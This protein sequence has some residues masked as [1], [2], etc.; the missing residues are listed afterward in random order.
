METAIIESQ[1]AGPSEAQCERFLKLASAIIFL[2]FFQTYTIAP[3]IPW[4]AKAFSVSEQ[5]VGLLVPAYTLPYAVAGLVCGALADRLGRRGLLFAS[6]AGIPLFSF[7]FAFAPN[8]QS[9][10]AV[11]AV[12]GVCNS[13]LVVMSLTLVGDVFP[14]K[15]RG[16]AT[17]WI[18][19]AI[20][21]G[22]A[23]GSTVAG[24][25][26]PI[27]GWRGLFVLTGGAATLL[28]LP[29]IN[30]WPTLYVPQKPWTSL[31]HLFA[32]Y[33]SILQTGRALRTYAFIFLN[34]MFHSGAF[35]WLGVH[36]HNRYGLGELGIG[37]ALL[38][39]GVPGFLLGPAIGRIV[40]RHGRRI[41]L[42]WGFAVAA[43][44]AALFVPNLPLAATVLA[45]PLLSLGFD[46]THPLLAGI[47]MSLDNRRRG[48]AI[49]LN[50][51]AVFFGFGCGALVFGA[52]AM[53]GTATAFLIFAAVQLGLAVVA[54]FVFRKE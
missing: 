23:F 5:T 12:S 31:K 22:S 14:V 11:R 4:L 9:L 19:G 1:R 54:G 40:D 44:A 16:R 17:G 15:S 39:Y 18:F 26:A 10:L 32:G 20:A 36:L 6:V 51:F 2:I 47:I 21:G 33:L 42:P 30:L 28:L 3:L 34:G 35:T 53:Y 45:V 27:V 48:Q 46:M 8:M 38:G 43:V 24:I 49:G 37:L 13:G 25:L 29:F 52:L 41:I 7:L 50:A